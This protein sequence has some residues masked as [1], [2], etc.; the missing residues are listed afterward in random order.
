M[1][2]SFWA[3][4]HL[5]VAEHPWETRLS[6]RLLMNSCNKLLGYKFCSAQCWRTFSPGTDALKL[7]KS[8]YLFETAEK[9]VFR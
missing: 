8:S 9:V 6:E 7:Q 1:F 5:E 4:V 3:I 2:V